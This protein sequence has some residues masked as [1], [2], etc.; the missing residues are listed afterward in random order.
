MKNKLGQTFVRFYEFV[1]PKVA[2]ILDGCPK[3]K[4]LVRFCL[5]QFAKLI[6][7]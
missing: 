5:R 1:S 3:F 7:S 6:N 2:Q 4:P